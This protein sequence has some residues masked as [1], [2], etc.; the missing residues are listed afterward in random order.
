MATG[1]SEHRHPPFVEDVEIAGHIIDSL[2][3]PKVLDEIAALGGR[4]EIL[5]IKSAESEGSQLCAAAGRGG[6][7][8]HSRENP[9]QYHPP[10]RRAGAARDCDV[11]PADMEGAFPEGFY[12]TTNEDTEIRIAGEW[13]PVDRRRWMPASGWPPTANRPTAC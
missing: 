10:W 4:H 11:C 6:I 3:L 12:S 2:I 8:R 13:L 9:L 7:R 1:T 5:E